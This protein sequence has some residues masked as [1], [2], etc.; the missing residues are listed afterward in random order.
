MR[1]RNTSRAAKQAASTSH[2]ACCTAR[3]AGE[4]L[5]MMTDSGIGVRPIA[6]ALGKLHQVCLAPARR[7]T[8]AHV[9]LSARASR[10]RLCALAGHGQA[11]VPVT[12]RLG[13]AARGVSR[14]AGAA[15]TS[16]C[17]TESLQPLLTGVVTTKTVVTTQGGV[18]TTPISPCFGV[19]TL[20][21]GSLPPIELQRSLI[22]AISSPS[23]RSSREEV[24]SAICAPPALDARRPMA[25]TPAQSPP[26]A[27]LAA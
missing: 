8:G 16:G 20:T 12:T 15:A 17:R 6:A 11:L 22:Q 23:S 5:F 13:P 4:L 24:P 7:Y 2:V 19:T 9:E 26:P 18:V 10:F 1:R 25:A 21:T 3:E 14:A 27:S